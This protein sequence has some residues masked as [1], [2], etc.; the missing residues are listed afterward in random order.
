MDDESGELFMERAELVC[1]GC[2]C[3]RLIDLCFGNSQGALLW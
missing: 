3:G 1:I 2:G